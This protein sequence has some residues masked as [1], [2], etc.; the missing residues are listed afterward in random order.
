VTGVQ[1]RA[2]LVKYDARSGEFIPFLGGI[3]AG[4]VDISRD[5][6]WVTYV[7][8][9]DGILWRSKLDGS[10][11]LQLTYSPA[12]AAL[13]HWS[14]DGKQIAFSATTPG[15][16][17]KVFLIGKDGGSPQ[18][19][20]TDEVSEA[21]PTWS[22]DGK[23]L[24]FGVQTGSTSMIRM[25]EVETHKVSQLAGSHN[26]FAPRWSP[27]G[28]YIED[29]AGQHKVAP[30]RREKCEMDAAE[31]GIGSDRLPDVVPRQFVDKFRFRPEQ[32]ARLLPTEG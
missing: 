22:A 13:A 6:Q 32:R 7:S 16:P 20:T 26:V 30:V 12:Q 5:G 11:R 4:D 31:Q 2:E 19:V 21:D 17:W 25:F 10:E 28:R 18:V 8:Y 24:A 15:K 23:R 3:S 14:P 9:P 27:N 29:L 1:P